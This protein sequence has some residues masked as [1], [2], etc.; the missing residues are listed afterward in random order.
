MRES[1]K[2]DDV[3]DIAYR[4]KY[5]NTEIQFKSIADLQRICDAHGLTTCQLLRYYIEILYSRDGITQPVSE[6]VYTEVKP[7]IVL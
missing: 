3:L 6:N 4:K 2:S 5:E 1:K 7:L